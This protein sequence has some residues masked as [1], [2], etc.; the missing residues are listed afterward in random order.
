MIQERFTRKAGRDENVVVGERQ[1]EVL[2]RISVHALNGPDRLSVDQILHGHE[3][4]VDVKRV[5][6]RHI[7][8]GVGCLCVKRVPFDHNRQVVYRPSLARR[9]HQLRALD[10]NHRLGRARP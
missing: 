6:T 7:E 2:D 8:I 1:M 4:A 10:A 5:P 3:H 9:A